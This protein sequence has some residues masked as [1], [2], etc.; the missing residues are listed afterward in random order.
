MSY[1][2]CKNLAL[3]C[4]LENPDDVA[5]LFCPPARPVCAPVAPQLAQVFI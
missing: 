1:A 4:G 5:H 3:T 2:L